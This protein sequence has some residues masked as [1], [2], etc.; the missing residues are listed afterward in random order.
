MAA[1]VINPK[2][3]RNAD[4]LHLYKKGCLQ[5]TALG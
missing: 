3:H 1:G 5:K 2:P 4:D